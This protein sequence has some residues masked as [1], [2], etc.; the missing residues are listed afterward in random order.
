MELGEKLRQ[1]RLEAG[2]SQRQLC[3]EVITRNMLSRVENGFARPSMDTLRYLAAT[4]GKPISYFLEEDAVLSPNQGL[5][6]R[7]KA[8]WEAGDFSSV[9]LMLQAFQLPDPLL[10]WEW[11]YLS[12]LSAIAAAEQAMEG[13]RFLYARSLLEKAEQHENGIP[14]LKQQRLLLLA[15]IPGADPTALTRQLP[16]LDAELM[17]RTEAALSEKDGTRALSLL[18]AMENQTHPNWNLFRGKAY[19]LQKQY[20]QAAVYLQKAQTT[21]PEQCWPLLEICFRELGDFEQAYK[22]ACKQR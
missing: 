8:N 21:A 4:L 7:A 6:T 5:M 12:F 13:S 16:S 14:G 18:D 19:L 10:E 15:K 11:R 1:A 2:L 22:Y 9:W 3:G 20:T 17:L